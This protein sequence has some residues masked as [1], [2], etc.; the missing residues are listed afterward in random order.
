LRFLYEP[1]AQDVAARRRFRP[2]DMQVLARHRSEFPDLPMITVDE[3]FG[4]WSEAH[5]IHFADGGVFDQ[6]SAERGR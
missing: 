6:I 3:V 2:S 5:R 4:G 1:V